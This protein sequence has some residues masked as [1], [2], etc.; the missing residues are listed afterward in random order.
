[1]KRCKE[2]NNQNKID[3]NIIKYMYDKDK[4][5]DGR[6]GRYQQKKWGNGQSQKYQKAEKAGVMPTVVDYS[7]IIYTN[8]SWR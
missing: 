6:F 8:G 1:M 2:P 4:N 5:C 7:G 3:D